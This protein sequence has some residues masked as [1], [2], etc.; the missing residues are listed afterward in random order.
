M[1]YTD[2][3]S[4]ILLQSHL[5]FTR[6]KKSTDKHTTDERWEREITE[7]TAL[8]GRVFTFVCQM[9]SHGATNQ[10]HEAIER[11]PHGHVP[12]KNSRHHERKWNRKRDGQS[13]THK[14][15]QVVVTLFTFDCIALGVRIDANRGGDEIENTADQQYEER[16]HGNFQV[17]LPTFELLRLIIESVHGRHAY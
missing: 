9:H 17:D 4:V 14:L 1:A 16:A 11:H 15:F 10:A 2:S 12:L 6:Q 3:T 13:V 8:F 7:L 5:R